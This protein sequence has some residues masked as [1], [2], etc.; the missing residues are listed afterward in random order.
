MKYTTALAL[1]GAASA[2]KRSL[3]ELPV[4]TGESFANHNII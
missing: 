4:F 3:M 2:E 1:V